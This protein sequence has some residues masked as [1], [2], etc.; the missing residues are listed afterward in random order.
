MD[1]KV[2]SSVVES[3]KGQVPPT[4]GPLARL[5]TTAFNTDVSPFCFLELAT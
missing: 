1:T 2:N 5:V 4:H 3:A